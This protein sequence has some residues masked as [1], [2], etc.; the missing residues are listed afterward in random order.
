M[1]KRLIKY[2]IINKQTIKIFILPIFLSLISVFTTTLIPLYFKK[3][4]DYV[5]INKRLSLN[6]IIWILFLIILDLTLQIISSYL[7]RKWSKNGVLERV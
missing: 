3:I 1:I 4:I 6:L 2:N 7:L 5:Q